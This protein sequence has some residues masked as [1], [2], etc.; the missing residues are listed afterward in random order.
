MPGNNS[1]PF[2]D[3]PVW[4][5]LRNNRMQL[6]IIIPSHNRSDLLQ[7]CLRSVT[8]HAPA[9]TQIVV[10]DDASPDGKVA[11]AVQGFNDVQLIT[12]PKRSGFCAA[13]NAGLHQ[14]RASIVQLLNDDTE[15][16]PNWTQVAC[17]RFQEDPTIASV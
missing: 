3:S 11:Q 8:R 9:Q 4:R 17:Q 6:S 12:L 13:I 16:L 2:Y 7:A 15:V 14:A 5:H 10:V 1:K